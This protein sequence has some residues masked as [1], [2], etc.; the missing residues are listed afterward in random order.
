MTKHEAFEVLGL[1]ADA[2][3]AA[4]KRAYHQRLKQHKPDRDPEGFQRIRRAFEVAS[5]FAAVE[6][7]MPSPETQGPFRQTEVDVDGVL[8]LVE[9]G[10][11]GGARA[12]V[13]DQRWVRALLDDPDGRVAAV[14]RRVGIASII[15]DRAEFDE[16]AERFPEVFEGQ[17]PTLPLL[18]VVSEELAAFKDAHPADPALTE[19]LTRAAVTHEPEQR[20]ALARDLASWF[21]RDRAVSQDQLTRLWTHTLHLGPFLRMLVDSYAHQL[22]GADF[23]LPLQPMPTPRKALTRTAA[24]LPLIGIAVAVGL[25]IAIAQNMW[26]RA[27]T[28]VAVLTGA[29]IQEGRPFHLARTR[30]LFLDACLAHA[31]TPGEAADPL[32]PLLRR[33]IHADEMLEIFYRVGQLGRLG[34]D[35]R[36]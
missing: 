10:E 23:P 29:W 6:L 34:T 5:D 25:G 32:H 30:R 33:S 3:A 36:G 26:L 13:T 24:W 15:S 8:A 31:I 1:P 12:R 9:R 2:Q 7:V 4:V 27:F 11:F 18:L 17:D 20:L 35:L 14:I 22:D 16:L 21:W 28:A 19:F